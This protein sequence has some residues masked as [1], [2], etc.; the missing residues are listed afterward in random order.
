MLPFVRLG[1]LLVQVSG[2]ALLVGIWIGSDLV[3]KEALRLRLNAGAI[4]NAIIYGLIAGL[5]GA[6]LLF[7]LEHLN[8]YLASPISIFAISG[9]ALDGWGGLCVGLAVA[10]LYGRSKALPFR[11]SL[12]AL[13]PGV[14]I[15]M[16]ALSVANLLSGDGYGL[17]L[18]APWA[19]Y[20]WGAYRHPTQ[21]YELLLA[22]GVLIAWWLTSR[23]EAVPGT[24]FLLVTGLSAAAL[25]F[26]EAFHADSIL[27][28]GGFR[29]AQ[30][31]ALGT[32]AVSLLLYRYWV[33]SP[34]HRVSP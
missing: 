16:I 14:A 11:H 32:L 9:T 4:L 12:D 19:I 1:P 34:R 3:E 31:L 21:I 15:F 28:L 18:K 27:T 8:A 30:L 33:A 24:R 29:L 26:T 13:A 7:A 20:L 5:L 17:P 10:F 23:I 2:L 25:L 22:V 6:R